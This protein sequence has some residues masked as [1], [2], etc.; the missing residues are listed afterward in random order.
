MTVKFAFGS[1]FNDLGGN[2]DIMLGSNN[3]VN[4]LS[5]NVTLIPQSAS[6]TIVLGCPEPAFAP[7]F[8][9]QPT[10]YYTNYLELMPSVYRFYWNFT[11]TSITGEVHVKTS[12]WVGFGLSPDGGMYNSDAFVGWITNDGHVNYTVIYPSSNRNYL[13]YI[14]CTFYVILYH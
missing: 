7:V 11:Q 14:S 6:S 13:A 4:I 3:Q 2:V 5:S 12:G 8:D 9:S 10:G 1:D